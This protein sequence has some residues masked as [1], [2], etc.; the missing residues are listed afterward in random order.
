MKATRIALTVL[1]ASLAAGSCRD[2]APL[3]PRPER[4]GQPGSPVA[5][6]A[7]G[8]S[9]LSCSPLPYDSVT[10]TIGPAGGTMQIGPHTLA[11]PAGALAAPTAITAVAPSD[12]ISLVEFQP[13]GL[14]FQVAASLTMS[15]ANCNLLGQLLP[16]Q[17]A[18]VNDSLQILDLLGSV[19]LLQ[20]TVTAR[21]QHFSGYAVAW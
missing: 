3:R 19:D 5:S 18:Y 17:I 15:Y 8:V 7:P 13:Q 2:A 20:G 11:V 10:D 12:T 14:Q 1:L 16:K 9:L 4:G 6:L 21:L